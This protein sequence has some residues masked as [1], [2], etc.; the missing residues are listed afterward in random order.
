[1]GT[2]CG[3]GRQNA[4][5]I[6]G[7]ALAGLESEGAIENLWAIHAI[8][9]EGAEVVAELAPGDEGPDSAPEIEREGT[10]VAVAG[11]ALAS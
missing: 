11:T 5:E 9:A 2:R 8:Q 3:I 4:L 1:M 6:I 10:S 7:E